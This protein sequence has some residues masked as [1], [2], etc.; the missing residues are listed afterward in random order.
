MEVGTQFDTFEQFHTALDDLKQNGY[1]PLCVYNSQ[2][3]EDYNKQRK[4]KKIITENTDL[5]DV[6]KIK[7]TYYSVVCVHYMET[8]EVV[9]RP[10]DLTSALLL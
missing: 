5:V 3:A 10:L 8:Q 7:Y 9:E 1:H 2:S 6:E 4:K